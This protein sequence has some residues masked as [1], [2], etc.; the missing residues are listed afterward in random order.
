MLPLPKVDSAAISGE[1]TVPSDSAGPLGPALR[2]LAPHGYLRWDTTMDCGRDI[3]RRLHR[4]HL[5]LATRPQLEQAQ[6][7]SVAVLRL[8][9]VSSLKVGNWSRAEACVNEIDHW[10][11]DHAS[12]TLQMRIRL[13]D[14]RG[15]LEELFGFIRLHQAWNFASP[16]RIAAAIVGAVDVCA[17]QPVERRD[18]VQ[19]AYDLFRRTW[20]QRL[21]HVIAAARGEPRAVTG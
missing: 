5:F 4:M 15:E 21:V 9:F 20:Y 13:L 19:A 17:I 8:E 3:L 12:A 7:P 16:R 11:L 2:V 18:G 1:V 6:V 10:N 14:A